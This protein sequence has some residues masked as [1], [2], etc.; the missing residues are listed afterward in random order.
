MTL[1]GGISSETLHLGS[2]EDVKRE[3]MAALEIAKELGSII[4]GCSNQV[5][6]PTPPQNIEVMLTTLH[7]NR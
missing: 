4:V 1:L 5:V 7:E 3:T 6:A 2:V